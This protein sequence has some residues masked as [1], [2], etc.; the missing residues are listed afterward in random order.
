MEVNVDRIFVEIIHKI[1]VTLAM[2][3]LAD[4]CILR[5]LCFPAFLE[6][7]EVGENQE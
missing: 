2:D 6:H 5:S 7:C 4:N 3:P 1:I